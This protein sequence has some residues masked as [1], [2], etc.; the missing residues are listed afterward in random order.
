[1]I[2]NTN[3]SNSVTSV[4]SITTD[5]DFRPIFYINEK[6]GL[7]TNIGDQKNPW[8]TFGKI[9]SNQKIQLIGSFSSGLNLINLSNV[10]IIG[11]ILNPSPVVPNP[12]NLPEETIHYKELIFNYAPSIPLDN[13]TMDLVGAQKSPT[14]DI[15]T[16]KM[17][18]R[19]YTVKVF[20]ITLKN[21]T[22]VKINGLSVSSSYSSNPT[23]KEIKLGIR[24]T[25][26]INCIVT[27][28]ELFSQKST[29]GWTENDWNLNKVG[30][31]LEYG[32][33]NRILNTNVYN[34]GGIQVS[35]TNCIIAG[36]F[37]SDFP[38]DGSGLWA[39]NNLFANN[40]VQNSKI[41]NT[42]HNDLFQS[43][44]C[45]KNYI[46]NN[47]FIAYTDP[48]VPFYNTAVQGFGCFDGWYKNYLVKNNF[49][50]VDHPIGLWLMGATNC[51]IDS[52]TVRLCG[53][54]PWNKRRTPCIL[55]GPKKSGE[56]STSNTIINNIAP[57]FELQ[58]GGGFRKN[59]WSLD[60][61][62]FVD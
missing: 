35:S 36:N 46:L 42:N 5:K 12:I 41:V 7:D 34:C 58:E 61:G 9:G 59:N 25:N 33:A 37:I 62:K 56:L 21:C 8:K 49:I 48:N 3:L 17:E 38:T 31:V 15:R 43:S 45:E 51:V 39:N 23:A 11:D 1:M 60:L 54:K 22:N 52:N 28:S 4:T 16:I 44:V 47:V 30:I 2:N 40:R 18:Q 29:I 55:L 26:C 20:S 24:L 50:F 6:I 10:E 27:N 53:K 13:P 57:H 14:Y 32:K 19:N